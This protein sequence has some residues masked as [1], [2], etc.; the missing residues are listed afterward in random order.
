MA[1]EDPGLQVTEAGSGLNLHDNHVLAFGLCS[2]SSKGPGGSVLGPEEKGQMCVSHGGTGTPGSLHVDVYSRSLEAGLP[3]AG[4]GLVSAQVCCLSPHGLSPRGLSS[5]GAERDLQCSFVLLQGRQSSGIGPHLLTPF[6]LNR[7]LNGPSP[8]AV[9]MGV[10]PPPR[11]L[12]DVFARGLAWCLHF[13]SPFPVPVVWRGLV[14]G[15]RMSWSC[16]TPSLSGGESGSAYNS[17]PARSTGLMVSGPRGPRSPWVRG[18]ESSTL[19]SLDGLGAGGMRFPGQGW[20]TAED[21][22][23]MVGKAQGTQVPAT[24]KK[25]QG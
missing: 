6:N 17:R 5:T 21:W 13:L 10:G 20:G 8:N 24:G 22:R 14:C 15:V 16:V 4:A 7:L 12:G 23:S 11:N 3:R 9:T 25:G 19:F 1:E 18:C 2:G